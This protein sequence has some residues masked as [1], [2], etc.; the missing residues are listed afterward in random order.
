MAAKPSVPA[1]ERIAQS[2]RDL[3]TSAALLNAASDELAQ[4]IAPIDAALKKLNIGVAIW[5][6]YVGDTDRDGDYWGRRIGYTKIGS[7]WGLALSSVEGNYQFSDSGDT[8]EWLYNDAP[9]WMRIEAVDHVPEL[10]EALVLQVDRTAA[11]LK[12]KSEQARELAK[13]ISAL[14]VDKQER[15]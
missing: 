15:R 4:A 5:H 13:T 8:E 10:L 1:S 7:K 11:D 6:Q 9:R 12:K 3:A 2:F 14:S